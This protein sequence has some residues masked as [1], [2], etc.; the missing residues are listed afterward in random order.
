[1]LKNIL[2]SF[3]QGVGVQVINFVGGVVLAR[4]LSPE[5]FGEVGILLFFIA[6][7]QSLI[8]SGLGVSLVRKYEV[9]ED[10]VNTVFTFNISVSII[11]YFFI[12]LIAPLI[13]QFYDKPILSALLK[14]MSLKFIFSALSITFYSMLRREKRLKEVALSTMLATSIS[15]FSAIIMAYNGYGVWSIVFRQ[16]IMSIILLS[17]FVFFR[18]LLPKLKFVRSKFYELFSFGGNLLV[19]DIVNRFFSNVNALVIGKLLSVSDIG[20]FNR[21]DSLQKT[22][23]QAINASI[24]SGATPTLY[25]Y[26]NDVKTLMEMSRLLLQVSFVLTFAVCIILFLFSTEITIVL[27]TEK[28]IGI[29]N[30]LKLFALAGLFYPHIFF[31]KMIFKAIGKSNVILKVE[32]VSKVSMFLSLSLIFVWRLEGVIIG[33]IISNVIQT[34]L[35]MYYLNKQVSYSYSLLSNDLFKPMIVSLVSTVFYVLLNM[36]SFENLLIKVLIICVVGILSFG[37]TTYMIYKKDYIKML[38]IIRK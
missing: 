1:M 23:I 4:L 28:W 37:V 9:D 14:V 8:D 17:L 11:I 27:L 13:S 20:L 12:F 6:I 5:E 29:V 16:I 34:V 26:Q 22:P 30:L 35:N 2:W 10:D 18:P 38:N 32:T 3:S 7:S 21:A 31:S 24:G 36:F 15:S 19:S 33:V 25:R